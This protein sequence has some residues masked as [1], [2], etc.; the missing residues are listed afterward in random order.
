MKEFQAEYSM[1]G[2]R[3]TSIGGIGIL[4][5]AFG[6]IPLTWDLDAALGNFRFILF[7]FIPIGILMIS[8][9]VFQHLRNQTYSIRMS[10]TELIW[11]STPES[12]A[13]PNGRI[14]LM[15]IKKIEYRP[16]NQNARDSLFIHLEDKKRSSAYEL[17]P[18]RNRIEII[19]AFRPRN[20]P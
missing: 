14:E 16:A 7:G 9:A 13:F 12:K 15:R 18:Q 11:R 20:I 10:E 6:S 3:A 5:L 8:S 19:S 4:L 1:R 2:W 17:L